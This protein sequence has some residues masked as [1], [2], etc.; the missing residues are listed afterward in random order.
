MPFPDDTSI[1]EMAEKLGAPAGDIGKLTGQAKKLTKGD[2]LALW[3]AS[4]T[5]EAV[6]LWQASQGGSIP[7][8]ARVKSRGHEDLTLGDVASVQELWNPKRV[9]AAL[10]LRDIS[11]VKEVL[12]ETD[13]GALAPELLDAEINI[14][15]CCC[16]CCCATAVIEPARQVA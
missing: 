16:P 15:C 1:V 9:R 14:Y 10:V 11:T 8:P 6:A 4:D 5:D 3:G 7:S 12:P 2:L 13:T